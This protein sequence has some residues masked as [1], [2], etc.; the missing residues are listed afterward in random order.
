MQKQ[1]NQFL[2]EAFNTIEEEKYNFRSSNLKR[3]E[4]R[5]KGASYKE[6][7]VPKGSEVIGAIATKVY[8]SGVTLSTMTKFDKTWLSSSGIDT[9][10]VFRINTQNVSTL[11]KLNLDKGTVS[12]FDNE[13]YMNTDKPKFSKGVPY[14]TVWVDENTAEDFGID[15]AS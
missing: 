12:W 15:V 4:F 6:K 3:V 2:V 8:T 11:V 10:N 5:T 14:T 7:T 9:S 1:Y 13:F